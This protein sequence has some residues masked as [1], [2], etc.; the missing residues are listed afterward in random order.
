MAPLEPGPEIGTRPHIIV[1]GNEKG[2]SGKSTTAM[3]IILGLIED[4]F[5]V[6]SIDLDSRQ[7]TLSRYLENREEFARERD[8]D[9]PMPRHFSISKSEQANQADA[10]SEDT[11]QLE[12][13]LRLLSENAEVIV[14]DCPGT[15]NF[16][17]RLAHTYADTLITP[18]NDSFV[19]LDL[20][21][22]VD[23]ETNAIE[24]PSVYS[25]MVWESRKR[26]ALRDRGSIDWIVIR[27]RI[28]SLDARNM[29][30]IRAALTD[31][32][33]RVGFRVVP[34]FGERVIF[35]ELFLKGLTLLDL[36]RDD[37]GD[38]GVGELSMSQVAARQEV[39]RLI[40]ELHL[41]RRASK[42]TKTT[43]GDKTIGVAG[44]PGGVE[45]E[46]RHVG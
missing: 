25:E 14:I 33:R 22:R 37:L 30:R 21:A 39:R 17:S 5:E 12:M 40:E 4:E 26:R 36:R 38:A 23:A 28:S 19:D 34:G 10:D 43:G 29:V 24:G 3:H 45:M 35:K 20:L 31:L 41:P 11:E 27:N 13:A 9:L 15:D 18:L 1:L 2:G 7:R 44:A 8:L 6:A 32:A 42:D 46:L 16:L